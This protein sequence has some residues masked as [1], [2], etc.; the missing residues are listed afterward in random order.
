MSQN[1]E[2]KAQLSQV[3]VKELL[4]PPPLLSGE[5]ADHYDQLLKRV[6]GIL[7]SR[8]RHPSPDPQQA[9]CG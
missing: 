6:E 4:G 9:V 7:W 3:D 1:D 8:R 5:N 2:P